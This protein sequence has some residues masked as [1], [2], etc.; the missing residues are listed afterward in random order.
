MADA[1]HAV[2]TEGPQRGM[3]SQFLSVVAGAECASGIFTDDQQTLFVSVQHPG[4]D[5]TLDEPQTMWP[6][7][8]PL[9]R[10]SVVQVWNT[11]GGK[12]G[13]GW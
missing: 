7:G 8:G 13:G 6:D 12:V 2:P 11:N 9:P 4:E 3:V 1:L 5:G 10:P